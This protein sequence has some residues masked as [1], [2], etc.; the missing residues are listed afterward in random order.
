MAGLGLQRHAEVS[1]RN[2]CIT[3]KS[4]KQPILARFF[5][6]PLFEAFRKSKRYLRTPV[7]EDL[8]GREYLKLVHFHAAFLIEAAGGPQWLGGVSSLKL[9]PSQRIPSHDSVGLEGQP[10]SW[11]SGMTFIEGA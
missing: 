6:P 9:L 1:G 4:S 2:R 8:S 11:S 7:V 5:A 10:W 3:V